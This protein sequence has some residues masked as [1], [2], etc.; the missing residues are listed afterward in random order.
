[1][2]S[3]LFSIKF[4]DIREK[5]VVQLSKIF[6]FAKPFFNKLLVFLKKLVVAIEIIYYIIW[7]YIRHIINKFTSNFDDKSVVLELKSFFFVILFSFF[8]YY[9]IVIEL[10]IL[11]FGYSLLCYRFFFIFVLCLLLASWRLEVELLKTKLHE[12]SPTA[13]HNWINFYKN[14]I[15]FTFYD[16]ITDYKNRPLFKTIVVENNWT[17]INDG[18]IIYSTFFLFMMFLY[19]YSSGYKFDPRFVNFVAKY[20]LPVVNFFQSRANPRLEDF[21]SAIIR[22]RNR[23]FNYFEYKYETHSALHDALKELTLASP[24][25]EDRAHSQ[26]GYKTSL[27]KSVRFNDIY[28]LRAVFPN[29]HLWTMVFEGDQPIISAS[30]FDPNWKLLFVRYVAQEFTNTKYNFWKWHFSNNSLFWD[31][32]K[33]Y[34]KEINRLTNATNNYVKNNYAAE[35]YFTTTTFEHLLAK[36]YFNEN[37]FNSKP[38]FEIYGS[39]W[40]YYN[41]IIENNIIE[42]AW[43]TEILNEIFTSTA[44][45]N[46]PY[47]ISGLWDYHKKQKSLSKSNNLYNTLY[48]DKFFNQGLKIG[49]D[50]LKSYNYEDFISSLGANLDISLYNFYTIENFNSI[51]PTL[52][53]VV[54]T[55][56]IFSNQLEKLYYSYNYRLNA[57]E[58]TMGLWEFSFGKKFDEDFNISYLINLSNKRLNWIKNVA[59]KEGFISFLGNQIITYQDL[60]YYCRKFFKLSNFM[61]KRSMK[62]AFREHDILKPNMPVVEETKVKKKPT[63]VRISKSDVDAFI[64]MESE[65]RSFE[66]LFNLRPNTGK[67]DPSSTMDNILFPKTETPWYIKTIKFFGIGDYKFVMPGF[68]WYYTPTPFP[69]AFSTFGKIWNKYQFHQK[70]RNSTIVGYSDSLAEMRNSTPIALYS[71]VEAILYFKPLLDFFDYFI[72]LF[73]RFIN[74]II[75]K[76]ITQEIITP[77][78]SIASLAFFVHLIWFIHF[79]IYTFIFMYLVYYFYLYYFRKI[80]FLWFY[81]R[82]YQ[83]NFLMSNTNWEFWHSV[84]E[85]WYNYRTPEQLLILALQTNLLLHYSFFNYNNYFFVKKNNIYSIINIIFLLLPKEYKFAD[86]IDFQKSFD[87]RWVKFSLKNECFVFNSFYITSFWKFQLLLF[88]GGSDVSIDHLVWGYYEYLNQVNLFISRSLWKNYYFSNG[89]KQFIALIQQF[90]ILI[91]SQAPSVNFLFLSSPILDSTLA[92]KLFLNLFSSLKFYFKNP[93]PEIKK[94]FLFINT[95]NSLIFNYVLFLNYRIEFYNFFLNSGLDIYSIIKTK[96]FN[97][98][99]KINTTSFWDDPKYWLLAFFWSF[100]FVSKIWYPFLNLDLPYEDTRLHLARL[101]YANSWIAQSMVVRPHF[102]IIQHLWWTS[103]LYSRSFSLVNSNINLNMAGVSVLENVRNFLEK[104]Y[105]YR[106]TSKT[107]TLFG[108]TTS[109]NLNPTFI[110]RRYGEI[111]FENKN[112]DL[113]FPAPLINKKTT[114]RGYLKTNPPLNLY[115]LGITPSLLISIFRN[116]NPAILKIYLTFFNQL[117][118]LTKHFNRKFRDLSSEFLKE[119]SFDILENLDLTKKDEIYS[120]YEFYFKWFDYLFWYAEDKLETNFIFTFDVSF[121]LNHFATWD[122]FS[123]DRSSLKTKLFNP[124]K[125]LTPTESNNLFL[126]NLDM[127]SEAT[128]YDYWIDKPF[129]ILDLSELHAYKKYKNI[130]SLDSGSFSRSRD[131]LFLNLDT[132]H[133]LTEVGLSAYP[134]DDNKDLATAYSEEFT[135]SRDKWFPY[136]ATLIKNQTGLIL[137]GWVGELNSNTIDANSLLY[138]LLYASP[139]P[140]VDSWKLENNFKFNDIILFNKRNKFF[141]FFAKNSYQKQF[142]SWSFTWLNL[143]LSPSC[144]RYSFGPKA[145]ARFDYWSWK[146]GFTLD[147]WNGLYLYRPYLGFRHSFFSRL[148]PYDNTYGFYKSYRQINDSPLIL[149]TSTDVIDY[150]TVKDE[151]AIFEELSQPDWKPEELTKEELENFLIPYREVYYSFHHPYFVGYLFFWMLVFT[152]KT[153]YLGLANFSF[154]WLLLREFLLKS[155]YNDNINFNILL[156]NWDRTENRFWWSMFKYRIYYSNPSQLTNLL[157]CIL[158][159]E[160]LTP[161]EEI[162]TLHKFFLF[163]C[164][165]FRFLNLYR[166]YTNSDIRFLLDYKWIYNYNFQINW[167]TLDFPFVTNP[168]L[169]TSNCT[170]MNLEFI[171]QIFKKQSFTFSHRTSLREAYNYNLFFDWSSGTYLDLFNL[172]NYIGTARAGMSM[173]EIFFSNPTFVGA[174]FIKY[175]RD[176]SRNFATDLWFRQTSFMVSD[177]LISNDLALHN[178]SL[179]TFFQESLAFIFAFNTKFY[180]RKNFFSLI[181]FYFKSP[182]LDDA[183]RLKSLNG[184]EVD[185]KILKAYGSNFFK[186]WTLLFL[187]KIQ[188]NLSY[189]ILTLLLDNGLFFSSWKHLNIYFKSLRFWVFSKYS[190]T[191]FFYKKIGLFIS[192]FFFK[193][194]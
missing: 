6:A 192:N 170:N 137:L 67:I 44:Y 36:N 16:F 161:M 69:S 124:S 53:K 112:F 77:I 58:S 174:S 149:D 109:L 122:Y 123:T 2:W 29:P 73:V 39:N 138:S 140:D 93:Q 11:L 1:M 127:I 151:M 166:G 20:F 193:R 60:A 113:S 81:E 119:D 106:D 158:D 26:R 80:G 178:L 33:D 152:A 57:L 68:V 111:P 156:P 72:W 165:S 63:L 91:S 22:F 70:N 95:T 92:R 40:D 34:K 50:S 55:R 7:Y 49:I 84:T 182:F 110:D 154:K 121:F 155:A 31:L 103:K 54:F 74:Y 65:L 42:K 100:R 61:E 5:I 89:N 168:Y 190:Q 176:E 24:R 129:G 28:F 117:D 105:S 125:Y 52:M 194:N 21:S 46:F 159:D 128:A 47:T 14:E 85:L 59:N 25:L 76:L 96:E 86:F 163:N 134:K 172:S 145:S 45:I 37:F 12:I 102:N 120:K 141:S 94:N 181:D 191:Q 30:R 132:E 43:N 98:L 35:G 183:N 19:M 18:K 135:G 38:L 27:R 88:H 162:N 3:T 66:T 56:P 13:L 75:E 104:R 177:I 8:F 9:F 48:H 15:P 118:T 157:D 175:P 139:E 126:S 144:Y 171:L 78:T 114:S 185:S 148:I 180:Q 82:L 32:I 83:E 41:N 87:F 136:N 133:S 97:F 116:S 147:Y 99:S 71:G 131:D 101:A 173:P 160:L 188:K 150:F 142:I 10:S 17:D 184:L 164:F 186:I 108:I 153:F 169:V 187:Y 79:Y 167:L 146:C 90:T 4:K 64:A 130:K 107:E 189:E 62:D 179:L 23:L 51:S 115:E 143:M